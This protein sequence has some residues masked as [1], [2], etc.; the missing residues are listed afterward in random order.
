M[1]MVFVECDGL[2]PSMSANGEPK[3]KGQGKS[4]HH[5]AERRFLQ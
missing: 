5:E 3:G 4:N 1:R 2:M